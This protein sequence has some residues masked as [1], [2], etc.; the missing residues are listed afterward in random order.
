MKDWFVKNDCLRIFSEQKQKEVAILHSELCV[1]N[2]SCSLPSDFRSQLSFKD[3]QDI[4]HVPASMYF[5]DFEVKW[6][7]LVTSM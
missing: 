4:Q 6:E 7:Y 5:T 2:N 1:K 3:E